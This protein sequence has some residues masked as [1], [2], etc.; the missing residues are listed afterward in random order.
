VVHRI[1]ELVVV[2]MGTMPGATPDPMAREEVTRIK[3]PTGIAVE[4]AP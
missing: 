4:I 3:I 1:D 2:Q